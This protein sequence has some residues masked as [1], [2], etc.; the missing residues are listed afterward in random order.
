[1]SFLLRRCARGRCCVVTNVPLQDRES[2]V[3]GDA[4]MT[5]RDE[6]SCSGAGGNV[7]SHESGE[8]DHDR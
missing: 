6:A 8:D 5:L 4:Q 1:M 2:V 7:E 3:F